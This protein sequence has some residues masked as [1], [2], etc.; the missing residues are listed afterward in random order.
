MSEKK[1]RRAKESAER[2]EKAWARLKAEQKQDAKQGFEDG[3][4]AGRTA[5]ED[6]LCLSDCDVLREAWESGNDREVLVAEAVRE[7]L[8]R[9]ERGDIL[10]GYCKCHDI[11]VGELGICERP[12]GAYLVQWAMGF[13]EGALEVYS[14]IAP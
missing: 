4:E 3:K 10:D 2:L 13:C 11:D 5:A 1:N 9:G 6:D 7:V 14:L 8:L 12:S